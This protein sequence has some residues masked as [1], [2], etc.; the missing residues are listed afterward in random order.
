TQQK[1]WNSQWF[2]NPWFIAN[3]YNRGW[4]RNSS[5]GQ[6]NLNYNITEGLNFTV[7][8]GFSYY[9][10]LQTEKEPISYLRG[11]NDL[12]IGN[13]FVTNESNYNFNT[14]AVLG[15]T[16][17][18][19]DEIKVTANIG[20]AVRDA[21]YLQSGIYTDG[22]IVP[23]FYNIANSANPIVGENRDA[24]ERVS[25]L[26]A[27]VDFEIYNAFFL[28]FTGRNDWVSTLPIENNS[29]FYPSVSAS[30][31]ISD[32]LDVP[33]FLSFLKVRSSFAQVSDGLIDN[34]Q[35]LSNRPYNHIIAYNEG[36]G[37]NNVNSVD[38]PSVK[39]N[40]DLKPAT[41][42]TWEVGLDARFFE[43]RLGLDVAYY[44]I[45]DFNNIIAVPVSEASGFSSR[46]ENGGEFRRRGIEILLSGTP[47]QTGDFRWDV[48]TN[49]TQYRRFLEKSP[50]GSGRLNNIDEGDRMDEIWDESFMRTPGGQYIIQNG[51]RVPDPFLRNVGFD[52][53]DW[54]FGV[55][56]TFTYKN[57][58][59][60]IS[61]DGRIGGKILSVT[62]S[63]MFWSGTHPETVRP[64]RDDANQGI[65]SY[66]DPGVVVVGGSAEYDAFGN[67]T[68]DSRVYAPNTTPVNYISWA[69]NNYG[70][71]ESYAD[72]YYDE[73]FFKLRE[74][75]LTYRIP[76]ALLLGTFIQE[77]SVSFVGRNLL[78]FSGVPQIDPDQGFDDQFQSPSTRNFGF[79][80]NFKF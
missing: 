17:A 37:W 41:S 40:P 80:V 9:S 53:A 67:I 76:S 59:L 68:S 15:Y 45:L 73:T 13:Y 78:L 28:G 57:L 10:L 49:W 30:V 75:I 33:E 27:T 38:F 66:V 52:D 16:T 55:Q 69:K 5:Y 2:N 22:L 36:S 44:N 11:F 51:S 21:Q 18:I 72:F 7:R 62:N 3:E 14:D 70:F 71:E 65:A 50:D 1:Q 20:G 29:F 61:G 4:F 23:S 47:I 43:G 34:D 79:N 54:V 6:L 63:E 12:S 31:V 39:I 46:L 25:S 56:Q 26:Y 60:G 74:V 8:S 64:E 24:T 77:A 35:G 58:S 19:T 48:S 32:L 42:R